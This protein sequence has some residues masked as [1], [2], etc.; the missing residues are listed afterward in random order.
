MVDVPELD[1]EGNEL[2]ELVAVGED[3]DVEELQ[4]VSV[5]VVH[6]VETTPL[7]GVEPHVEQVI[8]EFCPGRLW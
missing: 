1:G 2:T 4:I 8:Q 5:V 7:P 6:V 3:V